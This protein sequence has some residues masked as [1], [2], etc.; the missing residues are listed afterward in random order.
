[1][2]WFR[3]IF[4]CS[5]ESKLF[6]NVN[7]FLKTKTWLTAQS[8]IGQFVFI[9]SLIS[10]FIIIIIAA[11]T[12]NF[13]WSINNSTFC[14]IGWRFRIRVC[15]RVDRKKLLICT[16]KDASHNI[17]SCTTFGINNSPHFTIL[18]NN[19]H[20]QKQNVCQCLCFASDLT[21]LTSA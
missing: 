14:C 4:C 1:M 3:F 15:E 8:L 13:V 5:C 9:P 7:E 16:K 17:H 19:N 11:W 10:I 6:K 18:N 2:I 21:G 20:K 12:L